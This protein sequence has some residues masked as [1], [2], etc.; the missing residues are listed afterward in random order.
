MLQ[1]LAREGFLNYERCRSLTPTEEGRKI[2]QSVVSR[3]RLLE[4]FF[5][6]PGASKQAAEH[7]I[8]GWEHHL[9]PGTFGKMSRLLA[10]LRK[11]PFRTSKEKS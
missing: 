3:H 5:E 7:D 10:H 9:S 8:E 6:A 1:R 2:A 4:N 11:H